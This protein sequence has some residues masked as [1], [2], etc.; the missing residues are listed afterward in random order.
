M[1]RHDHCPL[2][3]RAVNERRRTY[4]WLNWFWLLTA[5][6]MAMIIWARLNLSFDLS[7]FVPQQT[8][9]LQEVLIEQIRRGPASRLLVV[10]IG[11]STP[12]KLAD[13]SDGLK[14]TLASHPAFVTVMNG[15]FD[16]DTVTVPSPV[17]RYYLLM[18]DVDYSADAIR[19][20]LHS[21]IRDLSF[22]GGASLR[23]I[24]ARDP[25]LVSLD[26]L[27]GLSPAEN[28]GRIWF[29]ADGS[30]VLM[31]ET[32]SSA[33]DIVA[34][35][36]A[37]DAV[38]AAFQKLPG[39][40]NLTLDVTGVGA[41]S[42]ELQET[43]RAEA[44]IRSVLASIALMS[45]IL[46]VFRKPQYVLL[47]ALPLGMGFGAGLAVVS[48]LFEKVHGITLAF[49]FTMLG[50]AIDYPVH[51]FAHAQQGNSHLAIRRI[52][53]TLRLGVASTAIA[54]LALVFSGSHGLAELGSFTVTGIIVAALVTRTWL[55][56]LVAPALP[57]PEPARGS[58][59]A[60]VLMWSISTIVLV[61]T[62]VISWQSVA[63]DLWDDNLSS[64]SPVSPE[65]LRTDRQ[66]RSATA[67]SDMQHQLL[68]SGSSL[69]AVLVECE[70]A[71]SFLARA[72][73]DGLL[74]DWQSV[75]HL[76]PSRGTQRKRQ[77][78]IPEVAVLRERIRQ[79]A[80]GTPFRANAFEP[81][82]QAISR[83]RD[84]DVLE[85]SR[86]RGTVFQSWMDSHLTKLGSEWVALI[87]LVEP[88][89][90]LLEAR[91]AGW[92]V[93]IK[94]LDLQGASL[95]LMQDY[96]T[97]ALRVIAISVILILALV[98]L[99]RG[100][101]RQM[102]WIG[103]TVA[104]ALSVTMTVTSLVHGGMTVMHLVAMLLVLGIG[105]DYA[106]FLSR[107]ESVEEHEWTGKGVLACAASTTL[108]FGILAGSSIPILQY[109]GLTVATGSAASYVLA[110]L[111]SGSWQRRVT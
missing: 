41:F 44:T 19:S 100:H 91:I 84:L 73:D 77:L 72:K 109:L 50:V 96:R 75:C 76:L 79:A 82:V 2:S 16:A 7:A 93:S 95:A 86:L 83:A 103:V 90:D 99:A 60:P 80:A 34:Q 54:Y 98:W 42:V 89:P 3:D 12:D 9:M 110:Y 24:V 92:P 64:L 23:R 104:A 56:H 15:E 21:R 47:A 17:D 53:P 25:F 57:R 8:T 26:I 81:F 111:G 1:A 37:I 32:V 51:L 63:P 6:V 38:K 45:V 30:T 55:P 18:R 107:S 58:A 101:L 67:T 69:D 105:L 28:T 10:G 97:R 106:L 59:R 46:I 35:R 33:I 31:A 11:G 74:A 13:V 27:E 52:W 62:S 14:R 48:L 70:E 4:R 43:I 29:A 85:P 71:D 49:G 40:E 20:A 94:A 39:A 5:A 102:L 65:R 66:F 87:T 108:A 88:K 36:E 78:A 61:C 68:L 22:G